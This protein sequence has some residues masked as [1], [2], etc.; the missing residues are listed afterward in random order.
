MK[1]IVNFPDSLQ[2]EHAWYAIGQLNYKLGNFEKTRS[3]FR[4]L[5]VKYPKSD[6]KD[7]AQLLIVQ[8]FL[9]EHNYFAA[10][11]EFEK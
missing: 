1:L 4:N 6:F 11:K 10:Y 8:T 5:I 7:D 9:D 2:I 3:A